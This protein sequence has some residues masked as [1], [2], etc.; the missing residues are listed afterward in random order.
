VW[1]V[2]NIDEAIEIFTSMPAGTPDEEGNYH[3]DTFW[4]KVQ[5]RIEY[6]SEI[7]RNR[8]KKS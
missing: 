6:F 7:A 3:P 4:Y 8:S 5:K 2:S 1:S